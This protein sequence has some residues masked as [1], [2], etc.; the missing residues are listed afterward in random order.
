MFEGKKD[1]EKCET[2]DQERERQTLPTETEEERKTNVKE[3]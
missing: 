2:M 1:G 3:K